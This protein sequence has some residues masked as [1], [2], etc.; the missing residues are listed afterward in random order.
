MLVIKNG[1]V[2][3]AGV[4]DVLIED[5]AIAGVGSFDAQDAIDATGSVVLPGFVDTHR[6]LVHSPMRGAGA[7]MTLQGYLTELVPRMST[8]PAED[9]RSAT[10]L[11]AV[12]ALNAGVTTLLSWG[13]PGAASV[14][15]EALA[16]A[17]IRALAGVAPEDARRLAGR[18][19]LVTVAVASWGPFLSLEDSVRDIATARSLGLLTTMHISREGSVARLAEAEL[20]A[21]DLHFV[22]G[23]GLPDDELKMLADAGA[24]LTVTPGSESMMMSGPPVHGR[25]AAAGGT[26]ALGVDVVL[27]SAADLFEQMRVAVLLERLGGT[28]VAANSVLRSATSDGARAIGLGDVTGSLEVGKRAD[29]MLLDGFGHLPEELVA[30]AVVATGGVA[31]V[32]T[33]LVDGRVVKRDGVL[34]DHDLAG[35][36]AAVAGVARRVLA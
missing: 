19:G 28:G 4:A 33:V 27:N 8:L 7:D 10:L 26:P 21:S 16:E 32:R 29:I 23:N 36:R 12:E 25:F 2:L 1:H 30:G 5:G 3:G 14:E 17:G 11:G 22:H 34:V 18:T 9:V 6:H 13:H 31:D 20:L 15:V 35:L 24:A